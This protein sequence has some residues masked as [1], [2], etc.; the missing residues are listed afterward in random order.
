[1]RYLKHLGNILVLD[2]NSFL[3]KIHYS[4]TALHRSGERW[5]LKEY[6]LLNALRKDRSGVRNRNLR[7][8]R[9]GVKLGQLGKEGVSWPWMREEN[10][11]KKTFPSPVPEWD[12]SLP[13][14]Q[15]PVSWTSGKTVLLSYTFT[16]GLVWNSVW[17]C[18]SHFLLNHP[19]HGS[20]SLLW[21]ILI[22][23]TLVQK[24]L[25]RY[26]QCRD[27]YSESL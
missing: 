10:F 15:L 13:F 16:S 5:K 21:K 25:L 7:A 14:V 6:C 8:I 20:C 9:T 27:N 22:G 11:F 2:L 17:L 3:R 23:G 26:S 12:H 19:S 4:E 18:L 1:M 24:L